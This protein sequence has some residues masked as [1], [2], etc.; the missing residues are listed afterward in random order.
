MATSYLV[1][2]S[3][4]AGY[5][6][7][8]WRRRRHLRRRAALAESAEGAKTAS[9]TESGATPSS[10][11]RSTGRCAGPPDGA[12]TVVRCAARAAVELAPCRYRRRPR[13]PRGSLLP[14]GPRSLSSSGATFK[15]RQCTMHS[16]VQGLS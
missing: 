11:P 13:P 1:V 12:P 4:D 7:V 14:Q 3:E 2:S 6:V 10:L 9:A 16:I 5:G 15:P 8:G